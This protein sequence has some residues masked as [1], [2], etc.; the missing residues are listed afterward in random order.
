MCNIWLFKRDNNDLININNQIFDSITLVREL[1]NRYTNLN[2]QNKPT[3]VL[4]H[5]GGVGD[6]CGLND[7]ISSCKANISNDHVKIL[8]ISGGA[9]SCSSKDTAEIAR[10]IYDLIADENT[11]RDGL[12]NQLEASYKTLECN[13]KRQE[14]KRLLV[15]LIIKFF[16]ISIYAHTIKCINDSEK[17][18]DL[19]DILKS[20]LD[21]IKIKFDDEDLSK[22]IQK[23]DTSNI[24]D[25]CK[26]ILNFLTE[27]QR[28][29]T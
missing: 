11:T 5:F 7:I 29:L 1:R 3:W 17:K 18:K 21:N 26:G 9:T 4:V 8:P 24:E 6:S 19:Y 14:K 20:E 28:T 22:L 13:I 10:K 25:Y 2:I 16:P 27:K 12:I 23:K 15:P